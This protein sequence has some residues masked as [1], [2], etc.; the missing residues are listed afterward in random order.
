MWRLYNIDLLKIQ[1]NDEFS[2][3]YN[4]IVAAGFAPKITLPTRI[5]DTTST[6]IFKIKAHEWYFSPS[7]I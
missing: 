3:F 4:N 7:Y 1:T 5:C 2:I 6:L